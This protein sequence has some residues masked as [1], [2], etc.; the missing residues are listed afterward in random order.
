MN[1]DSNNNIASRT[2]TTMIQ[3]SPLGVELSN[4]QAHAL[5]EA[6]KVMSLNDGDFL[7]EE[8]HIDDKLYVIANGK[9]EVCKQVAGGEYLGLQL[10][11]AGEMAGELGFID[12]HKHSASLRAV[13]ECTL[14]SLSRSR[15]ESFLD[16]DPHLV[17]AVMRAIFRT[18]HKILRRMNVQHVEMQNYI[19]RT[20]GR[21]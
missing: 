3:Q 17:Y 2:G 7:L 8:G 19:A 15:F 14:F 6:I 4:E 9:I 1:A 13:G 12:G 10:L 11:H 20:H 16:S 5:A 21:Y 18:V